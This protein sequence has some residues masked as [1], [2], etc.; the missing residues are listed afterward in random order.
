MK[1]KRPAFIKALALIISV[2][3]T[4]IISVPVLATNSL[5]DPDGDGIVTGSGESPLDDE[6]SEGADKV[7]EAIDSASAALDGTENEAALGPMGLVLL[8]LGVIAVIAIVF[9]VIPRSQK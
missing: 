2:F 5:G 6:I 8:L 3:L 7:S 9:I 1:T 4:F